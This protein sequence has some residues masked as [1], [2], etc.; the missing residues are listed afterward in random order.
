MKHIH[1]GDIYSHETSIDF[2]A[3]INPLGPSEYVIEAMTNCLYRVGHYPDVACRQLKA[4][5]SK[6]EQIPIE[7]ITCGNGAADIIYSLVLAIKPR[8]ALLITPSFAEYEQALQAVNCN[9]AYFSLKEEDG[10]QLSA[11]YMECLTDD[12]DMIFI[13]SP[14]NP[15]G[16]TIPRDILKNILYICEKKKILFVL[17]EC[18]VDFLDVPLEQTLVDELHDFQQLF[19]IKAFTKMYAIPGV[20][21][22][23]G[24]SGNISIIRSLEQCHQPW[25]VSLIAQ[26]AGVAALKEHEFV[27][28]SRYYIQ[29]ERANILRELS[30]IGIQYF[31]PEANYIFIKSPYDLYSLLIE[32]GILIRD[33]SNYKG[34]GKGYYRI[35][36]KST[37]ENKRI[38]QEL[39]EIY[40]RGGASHGQV[41]YDTGNDVK[42]G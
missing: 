29:R 11:D 37:E 28:K 2:S 21:L 25:N 27:K 35:A 13:C 7:F 36:V 24:L 22:G 1:G 4:A 9:V 8:K 32:V 23:Y 42:C 39:E 20:R 18:F 33:C 5:I 30:R 15:I 38:I 40:K 3:N 17:D 19:I 16:N 41:N 10:F 6:G 34:L 26:T 14:N 31:P 12:L